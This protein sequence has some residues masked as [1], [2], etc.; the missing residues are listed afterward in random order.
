MKI[1][2][3][4]TTFNRPNY[5]KECLNS[6]A[7]A[8]LSGLNEIL[9]I[10]DCS[11]DLT[12]KTLLSNIKFQARIH[13]N[14]QNKGIKGNLIFGYDELFKNN[15]IV[16]NLD[17]DALV[18]K[19]FVS[20]LLKLNEKFPNQI[21]TGFHSNTLNNNGTAR[22]I[23]TETG[24][25][26]L[27]KQSVGGIN[28]S[29]NKICYDN[30]LKPALIK[31]VGNFDHDAC[32]TAGGCI[33]VKES[34]I[35]HIGFDSSLNHWERPDTAESFYYHDLKDVT[36]F[37]VDVNKERLH[38]AIETC[39]KQLKFAETIELNPDIRSKEAYSAFII[40]ETYKYIKT[41]HVL[42]VQHDGY[43]VNPMVWDDSWLQYDYI[44]ATWWYTDGMNVGN[45]GFS[46]RSKRL[47][48]IVGTDPNIIEM[49]PEDDAICR[50][51]R[52]YLESNY[53]I[54]FAPDEVADKFSFEGYRQPEKRL[55]MHF[56]KHGNFPK[57][58]K[59]VNG[60]KLLILQARGLGDIL[61]L[62]PLVRALMEEGNEITWPIDD[63]YFGI[64]VHFMDL[65]MVHKSTIHINYEAKGGTCEY[66]H[67]I[68]YRFASELQGLPLTSCMKA[69]YSLYHHDWKMWRQLRFQRYKD[70]EI[71]L[72]ELIGA[73]GD[74]ILVNRFY[75]EVARGMQITPELPE[76][77]KIIEMRT[78]PRYTLIDWCTVIE[79][80][81]EIHTAS[82]SLLYILEILTLEMPIHFYKR[83]L[84]GEMAYEHSDYIFTK[85]YIL[86]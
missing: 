60:K 31:P 10:D 3:I 39:Q 24:Q 57:A 1:G 52:K 40:K 82:T 63:E 49:H 43:V 15:D 85:P 45:G 59:K 73:L 12:V 20:A 35:Q 19:D 46:L 25:D 58:N 48:E 76:G 47:M 6:L 32:I 66:G 28:F 84:W 29:I 44:G 11:T 34:V 16:I 2:L 9:I 64:S 17:S 18:S 38:L 5:L 72:A 81:T 56:G 77:K 54:K 55:D 27:R 79:N 65:N 71:R 21:V 86:H 75:G 4:L 74:Y 22:H 26:Y 78:I 7:Y 61:F 53:G 62:V 50:R 13:Y 33:C 30:Y 14:E 42:I 37:G 51:Y 70:K 41:S 80:A 23:I 69:K 67:I 83:G 36:L 8:D 68:P